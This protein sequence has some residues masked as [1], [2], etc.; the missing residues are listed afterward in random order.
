MSGHVLVVDDD[1]KAAELVS[2]VLTA[3]GIESA[4]AATGADALRMIEDEPA[5][6]VLDIDLPDANG[7]DLLA[8][9]RAQRPNLSVVMFT[10]FGDVE[11]AVECMQLG[12]C[13]FVQKPFQP[14]RLVAAV[15]NAVTQTTLRARVDSLAQ[16][17]RVEH[18]FGAIVGTSEPLQHALDL[19]RRAAQS[20]VDVLI[21]GESGTGKELAAHAV[22]AE[23]ARRDGP[24]VTVD[25]GGI[26]DGL[27]EGELFGHERGSFAGT[28]ASRRGA[29]EQADG[30]TLFLDDVGELRNDVQVR[31]L[32]ALLDRAVTRAGGGPARRVDVRVIAATD[33]DLRAE[34]QRGTF[35]DDLYYRLAVFPVRL[36]PLRECSADVILLAHSFLSR[37]TQ[38]HRR[39]VD[40]FTQE[41]LNALCNYSWPG[42]VRELE[43]AVERAVI[44]EDGA[45]LSLAS[46]PD[47]VVC[48]VERSAS[49]IVRAAAGT[50]LLRAVPTAPAP[51][52]D[53]E[54]IV[55][56]DELE[57]RAIVRALEVTGGDVQVAATRLGVSRATIY[58]RA[59]RYRYRRAT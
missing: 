59:E 3:A 42:N 27:L 56:L 26:P 13:D 54:E 4:T 32:R 47:A 57:R 20:E 23:S 6:V 46:L 36:P 34:I 10:G 1:R 39:S 14:A 38:R 7:K 5:A 28:T 37:F 53:E 16:E 22:H 31:V 2:R 9:F 19:L 41:A 30:G 55:P 11:Q 24:F 18:G 52:G 12:A 35:R 8:R 44:L 40:G 21:E 58:R 17:L 43:N 45:A 48:A 33:R 51:Q 49:S 29:F 50:T 25:C 15:R